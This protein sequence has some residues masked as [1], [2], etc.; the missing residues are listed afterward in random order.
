VK[1]Y[2]LIYSSD[3]SSSP[4]LVAYN[5]VRCLIYDDVNVLIYRIHESIATP[6]LYCV[7]LPQD[8]SFKMCSY[9]GRIWQLS[10]AADIALLEH[11][12]I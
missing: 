4:K 6:L 8:S 9:I 11:A 2:A 5:D 12:W 3:L 7:S 1:T 10:A